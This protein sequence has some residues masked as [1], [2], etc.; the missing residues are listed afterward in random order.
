MKL[1]ISVIGLVIM[2]VLSLISLHFVT[3]EETEAMPG[4][5][6]L[7]TLCCIH[8]AV[9]CP[10]DVQPLCYSDCLENDCGLNN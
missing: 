6:D 1:K 7:V 10:S 8:Y 5:P 9:D 3:P 2:I 4:W